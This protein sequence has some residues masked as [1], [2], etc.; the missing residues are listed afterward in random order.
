MRYGVEIRDHDHRRIRLL[1][2][3]GCTGRDPFLSYGPEPRV[4]DCMLLQQ[5]TPTR[6]TCNGKQYTSLQLT[7]IRNGT[8][9]TK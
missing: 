5:S 2:F 8:T 7:D 9:A 1:A 6:F 4:E 3:S